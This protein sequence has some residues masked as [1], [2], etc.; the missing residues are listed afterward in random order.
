MKIFLSMLLVCLAWSSSSANEIVGNMETFRKDVKLETYQNRQNYYDKYYDGEVPGPDLGG[1]VWQDQA[2]QW[3]VA[4]EVIKTYILKYSKH[5]IKSYFK[6][7]SSKDLYDRYCGFYIL[8]SLEDVSKAS[9][10]AI[11]FN[12]YELIS[13]SHNKKCVNLIFRKFPQLKVA[14]KVLVKVP[15]KLQ[16]FKANTVPSNKNKKANKTLH[17]KH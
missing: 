15:N 1:C 9:P 14:P 10:R 2:I 7:L 3:G 4:M 16:G 8:Q 13:S 11:Y 6:M 17:I 5:D 12:P